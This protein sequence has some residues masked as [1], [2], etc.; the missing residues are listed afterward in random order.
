MI[1][2][3]GEL[4]VYGGLLQDYW[5]FF[6]FLKPSEEI[7]RLSCAND[8]CKWTVFEPIKGSKQWK[9]WSEREELKQFKDTLGFGGVSIAVPNAFGRCI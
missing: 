2:I 9:A 5:I 8:V 7:Y 1:F 6:R 3:D 4:F